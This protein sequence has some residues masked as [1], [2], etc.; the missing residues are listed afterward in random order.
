MA[1]LRSSG[2]VRYRLAAMT[3]LLWLLCIGVVAATPQAGAATPNGPTKSAAAGSKAGS[4][5]TGADPHGPFCKKVH[6]SA[7]SLSRRSLTSLGEPGSESWS[8]YR[9]FQALYYDQLSAE[10][11]AILGV[12]KSV[13]TNVRTAAREMLANATTNQKLIGNAKSPAALTLA[14]NALAKSSVASMGALVGH[15]FKQCGSVNLSGGFVTL[16][17]TGATRTEV[18]APYSFTGTDN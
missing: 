9:A 17:G 1:T 12:G 8:A 6:A 16:S 14:M 10:S 3:V 4:A 11:R 15:I 2:G 13:P 18:T 5:N 7:A